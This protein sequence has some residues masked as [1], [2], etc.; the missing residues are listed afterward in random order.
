MSLNCFCVHLECWGAFWQG[1]LLIWGSNALSYVFVLLF[2]YFWIL[3]HM[4]QCSGLSDGSVLGNHSW[5]I[6]GPSVVLRIKPSLLTCTERARPS[7]LWWLC[8]RETSFHDQESKRIEDTHVSL[9]LLMTCLLS[10]IFFLP[11][12][13]WRPR[14]SGPCPLAPFHSAWW[15]S[16]TIRC[17]ESS[18]V[19]CMRKRERK[20]STVLSYPFSPFSFLFSFAPHPPLTGFMLG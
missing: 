2:I 6:W 4:Q 12:S 9:L 20:L 7:A 13:F 17:Q 19:S 15:N 11:F 10:L 8:Y 14:G 16:W 18:R 1:L 5:S 3:N